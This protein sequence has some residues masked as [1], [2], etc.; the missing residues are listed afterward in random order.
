MKELQEFIGKVYDRIDR[1]V[2]VV[3][4]SDGSG[5]FEI[6]HPDGWLVGP[7]FEEIQNFAALPLEDVIAM[8]A[9]Q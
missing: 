1:P 3:L 6:E 8:F 4:Y 2:R 5:H 7:A 9:I